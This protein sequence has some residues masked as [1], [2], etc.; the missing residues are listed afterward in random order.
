M[1]ELSI[2]VD[3]SGD[4]GE[5]EKHSPFYIITMLFHDQSRDISEGI[6]KLKTEIANLGY[7]RDFVVHTGPLIRKEEMYCNMLPN[8]RRAIF[9]K[10]FFFTVK[11]DISY[12]SFVYDKREY[13]TPF[14][15]EARMARDMSV[16]LRNNLTYFQKYDNIILYY[17]NG[18][19][20]ITRMLN[21]V[22]ATEIDVHD[23]RRVMPKDY[24]LFQAADLMCTLELLNVKCSKK[25]LTRSELVVFHSQRELYKQF[26]KPIKKKEFT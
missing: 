14:K 10:L 26:I 23:V 5:Y 18:Q 22:L 1:K 15:M 12:K 7:E 24:K 8:E 20:Q 6:A 17:D 9:T 19:K 16:F 11:S 21:S 4:F 13:E 25:E 3:E 2:F